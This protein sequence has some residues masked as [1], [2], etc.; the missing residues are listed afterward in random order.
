MGR[1]YTRRNVPALAFLN[2][3]INSKKFL[4][5]SIIDFQELLKI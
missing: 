1:P 2:S 5:I 3:Q 4:K